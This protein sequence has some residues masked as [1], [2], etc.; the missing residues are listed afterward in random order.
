M[1]GPVDVCVD[2]PLLSLDRPFTYVLAEGT[3]AGV[4]SLVSVPFHGRTLKGWILGPADGPLPSRLSPVRR[5][6]SPVRF[7]DEGMLELFRWVSWRYVA[8]LCA[9]IERSHP[10]RVAGVERQAP[11]PPVDQPRIERSPGTTLDRYGGEGVLRAGRPVWLRPQPDEEGPVCVDAVE[12]TVERGSAAIVLVPEADPVPYTA[13]TVLE[14][15]GARAAAFLGGDA[16]TRYRTWVEILRGRH[17][18]VVATRPGVFAPLRHLGLIWVCR[19]AHPAHREDRAPH[20]HVR[21]VA[22]A[23]ARLCGAA[24]VVSSLSPSV[25]VAD[26]V[27]AGA[28]R[29]ARPPRAAERAAAPL[30]ETV[31]PEA[32]D[33]SAR[34]A[35]LLRRASSAVVLLTRRGYGVARVCRTCGEPAGCAVCG[36]PVGLDRGTATCRTCGAPGLCGVCGGSAFGV[37]RGGTASVADWAARQTR[38]AVAVEREGEGL[39]GPAAGTVMVATA[40]AVKDVG[41]ARVDVVGILDP[42][43]ALRRPGTRT[44]ERILATWMEAAAWTGPRTAPRPGRVLVQTRR[45][46]HPAVQALVRWEPV[47]FLLEE[48]ERRREAGFPPNH[49]V[50]RIEGA[51]GLA[52][53]LASAGPMTQLATSREGR[54]VCLVAVRPWE[55]PAFA[56]VVRDLVGARL[57]VRVEAEPQL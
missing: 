20:H 2:V 21:E 49:P 33:R 35:A 15:F 43:R 47:P 34:L 50:F 31:P 53:A 12:R 7:F 46:G 42:D 30:V 41:P 11:G 16:R 32:E 19:D 1:S 27:R 56:G 29:A 40:A 14:R 4:G 44:G 28:M 8:P 13:A 6:R 52:D 24:C 54:T 37:E 9:V 17:D 39:P 22:F 45:P 18:V 36:G 55:L 5:V 3:G 48:A 23:R 38:L 51:P 25:D 26:L 57:V 10:P